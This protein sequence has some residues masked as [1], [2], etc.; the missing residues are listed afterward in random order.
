MKREIK[1]VTRVICTPDG[2][3]HGCG[4]AVR[5][6]REYETIGCGPDAGAQEQDFQAEGRRLFRQTGCSFEKRDI[7]KYVIEGGR[8]KLVTKQTIDGERTDRKSVV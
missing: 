3:E 8:A 6:E 7:V 4:S 5:S 2:L 1:T